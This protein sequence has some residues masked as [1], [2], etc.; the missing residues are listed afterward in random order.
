MFGMGTGGSSLPSSPLWL[1]TPLA[2]HTY[3]FY[4][5]RII[6][7]VGTISF[8]EDLQLHS[9]LIRSQEPFHIL[10]EARRNYR[11]SFINVKIS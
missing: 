4:V 6:L 3:V 7:P 11:F 10:L 9:K 1:Y 5:P 8:T 2:R